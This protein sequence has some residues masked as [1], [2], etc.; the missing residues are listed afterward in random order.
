MVRGSVRCRTCCLLYR[1]PLQLVLRQFCGV[2]HKGQNGCHSE[3]QLVVVFGRRPSRSPT[4]SLRKLR[5]TRA[6]QRRLTWR[7][8]G[9]K[10]VSCRRPKTTTSCHSLWHPFWPLWTTPQNCRRT[11]WR[12]WRYNKQHVL[13]LTLPRTIDT[14]YHLRRLRWY[15]KLSQL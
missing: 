6:S 3:W 7:W 14:K 10:Q 1:Q 5:R 11:S 15:F 8:C 13:H 4:M 9:L 2:V 12:G